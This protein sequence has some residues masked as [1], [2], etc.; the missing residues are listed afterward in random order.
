VERLVIEYHKVPGHSWDELRTWFG[1]VGLSVQHT[2][3][4]GEGLGVVWLSRE[5]LTPF[6]A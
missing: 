2:E 3:P 1:S 5:A 6:A 4:L